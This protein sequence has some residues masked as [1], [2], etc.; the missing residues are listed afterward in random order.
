[1]SGTDYDELARVLSDSSV[2]VTS[3]GRVLTGDAA[4]KAGFK[5][6]LAEYRTVDAIN[7]AIRRGRAS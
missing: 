6:L 5:F 4:A 1:M 3:A 7:E 2:P